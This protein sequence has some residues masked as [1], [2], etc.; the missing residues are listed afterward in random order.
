MKWLSIFKY[1]KI[2]YGENI[3]LADNLTQ[4]V[5][6]DNNVDADRVRVRFTNRYSK[7]EL[8]IAK[9]TITKEGASK[10]SSITLDG[11]EEIKLGPDE[12]VFSDEVDYKISA[13]DRLVISIYYKDRQEMDSICC[14]WSDGGAEVNYYEGDVTGA[15][16]NS[17]GASK[18]TLPEIT[19]D[20]LRDDANIGMMKIFSGFDIVQ[21]LADDDT[22]VIAAFGDSITHMSFYTNALQKRLYKAYPGKLSLIN[23]GI[24]GNRLVDD[25][26]YVKAAGKQLVLFGKAGV[27]RFEE[28]VFGIDEVD[29]VLTLIGINDIMH[30][31]FLEDKEET[32]SGED[33]VNGYKK[34]AALAHDNGAE[35]YFGTITP[36]G[37]DEYPDWWL[38]KFE[39]S[40]N[41]ANEW[42]RSGE[43]IDGFFDFDKEL[44]NDNKPGYMKDDCN[45][46]DGLHPNTEG[47]RRMADLVDIKAIVG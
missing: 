3:A 40:R 14:F 1:L 13:G 17:L 8:R 34:I 4:R 28:D 7:N 26:T 32:T 12:V 9:A 5:S 22:K 35:I 20:I 42:I 21:A 45:I 44:R 2:G 38:P 10:I 19:S 47:G 29:T 27:D 30:P 31:L 18:G 36:C 33:I 15:D 24:G 41:K 43:L 11:K 16:E 6:F 37:N 25:A 46:G 23:C 39:A